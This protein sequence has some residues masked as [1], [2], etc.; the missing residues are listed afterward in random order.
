MPEKMSAAEQI[1]HLYK[2]FGELEGVSIEI[3]HDLIAVRIDNDV[4]SAT[5]FLQGAQLAEF[6]PH[7]EKHPVIWCSTANDYKAGQPLRG[8]IPVCWPWFGDLEQNSPKVKGSITHSGSLPPHGYV[9]DRDWQLDNIT[10]IDNNNTR[11]S[12]SL[13]TQENPHPSWPHHCQLQLD[14]TISDRLTM[15]FTVSNLSH[16]T[17][18]YSSALHTYY[19]IGDIN[20]T[21]LVG[22]QSKDY[23][24]CLDNW[25]VH[26]DASPVTINSE[27]D[28]IYHGTSE[29]ITIEDQH[30][31]RQIVIESQ[32]SASAVV[33]NPWLEKAK[34]LNQFKD[35]AY[36]DMLCV[37]S[38]NAGEDFVELA[39][40]QSHTLQVTI[41]TLSL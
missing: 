9:R 22:L 10:I 30:W 35:E 24:N 13:D 41:S 14:M 38:A 1:Q 20:H 34:R 16:S 36:R 5:I 17:F 15:A 2:R 21:Q 11:L 3:H 25:S 27:V 8:G 7:Q 40:Q 33:W 4:A 23:I 29:A 39:P 18:A 6:R 12:F 37:E 28:R 32:G 19:A 26:N 31:Q